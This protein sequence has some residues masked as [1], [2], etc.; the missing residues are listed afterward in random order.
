MDRLF[1]N[2]NFAK[3]IWWWQFGCKDG[4]TPDSISKLGWVLKIE[5][6]HEEELFKICVGS[7]ISWCKP[8][9]EVTA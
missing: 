1:S 8:S 7:L 6:I 3:I 5:S 4:W 9:C 2:L